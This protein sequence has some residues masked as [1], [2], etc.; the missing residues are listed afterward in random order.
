MLCF[1]K[2]LPFFLRSKSVLFLCYP[3]VK[4]LTLSSSPTFSGK[5]P[6]GNTVI[7]NPSI[8]STN[9]KAPQQHNFAKTQ[10]V[11]VLNLISLH[12]DQQRVVVGGM[13]VERKQAFLLVHS[14]TAWMQKPPTFQIFIQQVYTFQSEEIT[15]M[16]RWRSARRTGSLAVPMGALLPRCLCCVISACALVQCVHLQ[17]C[18]VADFLSAKTM[19]TIQDF[20]H[21]QWLTDRKKAPIHRSYLSLWAF[22]ST[23][24]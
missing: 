23:L 6:L 8:M 9:N 15:W 5:T 4:H 14:M 22:W 12:W 20:W 16:V 24:K 18:F 11:V 19:F 13:G 7:L 17:C 3:Q 21:C 1:A 2:S 10:K